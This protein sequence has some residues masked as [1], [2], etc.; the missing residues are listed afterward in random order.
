MTGEPTATS[1]APPPPPDE[2]RP[3]PAPPRSR[4]ARL[5]SPFTAGDPVVAALALL[6]VAYYAATH[7]IFQGKASGDG[8]FGFMYLPNLLFFH[9][10]D[11]APSVPTWVPILGRESTGHVANACPIGPALFW[12]PFYLLGLALERLQPFV[13]PLV[14]VAIRLLRAPLLV[15]HLAPLAPI[16]PFHDGAL[17]GQTVFD[18]WMAG[19]G[20][21]AAGIAGIASAFRLLARKL[22][23]GPARVGVVAGVLATPIVWYLVTQPLYQHACAFF[24]VTLLVERWDAWRSEP[25]TLRRMAALGAIGGLAMLVRIQEAIWLLL[26][27]TDAAIASVRALTDKHDSSAR[28]DARLRAAARPLL[29]AIVLGSVAALVFAPQLALWFY[30]FGSL[31]TPQPPGH[32]RW[33]D[34]A[35]VATLFSTRGG[36]FPWMPLA[37]LALPGLL[38]ARRPL[39]GL[40]G[41]LLGLLALEVWINASAWDHW[42]SW[43][44]GPR[45]F[46]DATLTF[47]AGAAGIWWWATRRHGASGGGERRRAI[48]R[49]ALAVVMAL[50]VALN[51]LQMELMRNMRIKSSGS[52]SFPAATWVRWADGP[53][54]LASALER[55]G[56]PFAQPAGWIWSLVYHV[57]TST[58]EGV[59]GGYLLERDC[60]IHSVV[61]HGG[62]SFAEPAKYVPEGIVGPPDAAKP[63]SVP[64]A[65]RV[66]VL[67]PLFAVEPLRV[68]VTGVFDRTHGGEAAVGATWNG[69]PLVAAP[70]PGK[71]WFQVPE[72]IVHSRSRTN[73]LVLTVP[74]GTRLQSLDLESKGTWWW[75]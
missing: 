10:F 27:L 72:R 20:S 3:T 17:P 16:A 49:P 47:A 51:F 70:T 23:A 65:R 45:R 28:A 38:G 7:G 60:R 19:L 13:V 74:D 42:G 59:V 5:L 8:F 4:A 25:L 69:E 15:A 52:W 66:R 46:T 71:V 1:D 14:N 35:I 29:G 50:L 61:A 57:P 68:G 6:V 43:T 53:R 37:Y 75:R 62:F 40:G 64:V 58:F 55:V 12:A 48:A 33:L 56:W 54:W 9:T 22:G 31:R 44:Y 26:P 24:A 11:I 34:P 32:M 30:Y 21:L 18:F 63:P 73:E 2:P 67:V 39:G 41:R 36:L